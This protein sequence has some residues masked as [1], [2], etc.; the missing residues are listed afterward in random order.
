MIKKIKVGGFTTIY[1]SEIEYWYVGSYCVGV[2]Q[3]MLENDTP[4]LK[5]YIIIK[6]EDKNQVMLNGKS[7]VAH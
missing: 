1:I 2:L 6:R 4:P 5:K 3:E 7:R